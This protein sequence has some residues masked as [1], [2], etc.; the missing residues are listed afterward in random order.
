MACKTIEK[1]PA[2]ALTIKPMKAMT[3]VS[4]M[5]RTKLRQIQ[6]PAPS[7]ANVPII[8]VV[9]QNGFKNGTAADNSGPNKDA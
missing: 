7:A 1:M 2:T 8:F 3:R 5:K 4:L 6:T 9:A